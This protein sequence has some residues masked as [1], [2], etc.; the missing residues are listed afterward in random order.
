MSSAAREF[1]YRRKWVSVVLLLTP[2]MLWIGVVYFGAIVALV[3]QSF[4]A[5]D[6]FTGLVVREFTLR[7]YRD[8]LTP[9]HFDI[10]V[11]TIVMAALVTLTCAALAFPLAYTMAMRASA[12]MK[13]F[14]YL[15]VMLPL[16]SSY[17]VRVYAWKTI[18]A[19]EGIVTWVA[20]RVGL[21]WLL[22]AILSLPIVGGSSLS[23]SYIGTYLVFV[24]IWLPYMVLPI[25]A[26]LQR[27]PRSFLE[28]SEDLGAKGFETFRRVTLP[29]ALPGVVAGSI[30]TFSLTLGDF[31]IPGTIG[32]SSYF[33]GQAVLVQ[34]GTAGNIPLA[35]AM[36]AVPMIV[37]GF[38]LWGAKRLGAFEAL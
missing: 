15:G 37:M 9:A 29:L 6:D 32:N 12:R 21:S 30:F 31:I 17:I 19:K 16:W 18:L 38:Y 23:F 14:L 27:I 4:Y 3:V 35:A 10:F 33:L 8:L 22:E 1:L 7:T 13:G 11:R 36:T 26:A 25:E 28:A 34:Q 2:P 20:E 24:Y 5:L